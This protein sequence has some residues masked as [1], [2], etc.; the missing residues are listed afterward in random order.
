MKRLLL[1]SLFAFASCEKEPIRINTQDGA[2]SVTLEVV[3]TS[4]WLGGN[5][6]EFSLSNLCK[7][8][9]DYGVMYTLVNDTITPVPELGFMYEN[10]YVFYTWRQDMTL[11]IGQE[12]W[13]ISPDEKSLT[14]ITDY[15]GMGKN[16][17]T[18]KLTEL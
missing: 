15:F 10:N 5:D 18:M 1:L 16:Q 11:I 13:T 12:E 2:Y 6:E 4:G 7:I 17:H 14:R 9:F 3:E 8:R